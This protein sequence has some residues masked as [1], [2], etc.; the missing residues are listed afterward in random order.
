MTHARTH[1]VLG[2]FAA[3]AGA[4]AASPK[5][6]VGNE[7]PDGSVAG[8]G[9]ASG[10]GG[11]AGLGG[12]GG[13]DNALIAHIEN[14]Q[15]MTIEIVT[16]S[17]AGDCADVIAV[18][19]GG[20]PGYTFAWSDGVTTAARSVCPDATTTYTVTV[21]DTAFDDPEF[22]YDA[23]TTTARVTANVLDCSDAGVL[24]D[25]GSS[26]WSTCIDNPSFEGTVTATQFEAFDAP[27]WNAC[28]VGGLAYAAIGD[29]T[30]WPLQNWTFPAASDGAT[31]LA[32]GQQLAFVGRAS[33]PLC[34][35]ITAG[36]SRSF[37]VDLARATSSDP[38][39]EATEQVVRVFGG[40]SCAEDELLWT[41]P[42]LTT[43]WS[44]HCVTLQ[45]QR[46]TTHLAFAPLGTGGG[47]LVEALVDHIV[48]VESCP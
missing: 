15:A 9:G 42:P 34:E 22:H 30:L 10:F 11:S 3:I 23:Q 32:L 47:G 17:C 16:I 26:T 5:I 14:P 27:P 43:T 21:T 44:A 2:F 20:N 8:S 40:D 13:G 7:P 46:N 4:C 45:P 18:A 48:P 28:Y 6:N 1:L 25:G 35:P 36:A 39:S 24:D 12:F 37:L 31:Y 41:S 38:A 33:Q 29:P 19:S